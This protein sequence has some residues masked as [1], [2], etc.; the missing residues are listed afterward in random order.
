[1]TPSSSDL[2]G[3][4]NTLLL[5]LQDTEYESSTAIEKEFGLKPK[6]LLETQR[7]QEDRMYQVLNT[8]IA[9]CMEEGD[10]RTLLMIS[11]G[12]PV[13]HLYTKLTGKN[14]HSHGES[15]YCCYSIYQFD[16]NESNHD[17]PTCVPLLVNESKYLEDLWSDS[18]AN[19]Y[20][21]NGKTSTP[22]G[23]NCFVFRCQAPVPA[24]ETR[25][26]KSKLPQETHLRIPQHSAEGT[27]QE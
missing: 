13:T 10:N 14:W 7:E 4:S 27:M 20:K 5:K 23:R 3:A 24:L 26:Y 19:I 18:T 16:L 17:M 25:M 2:D 8:K 21:I 11:H 22:N 1:M 15:K 12:G 6:C 9:S